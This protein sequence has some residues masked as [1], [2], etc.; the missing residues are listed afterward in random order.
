[1]IADREG[2]KSL[3]K[4]AALGFIPTNFRVETADFCFSVAVGTED[5]A[6]STGAPGAFCSMISGRYARSRRGAVIEE[7]PLHVM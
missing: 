5:R 2:V 7:I 3:I 1:M 4:N 6:P